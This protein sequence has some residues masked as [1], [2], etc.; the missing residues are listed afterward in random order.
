MQALAREVPIASHVKDYAVRVL[1]ATHPDSEAA[2][3]LVTKYVRYGGSPRGAQAIVLAAKI[4]ALLEGRFNVA[5]RT[6]RRWRRRRCAI[7]SSSTSRARRKGSA[8]TRWS[9]RSWPRRAPNRPSSRPP[10]GPMTAPVARPAEADSREHRCALRR[11]VPAT[12]RAA[13]AGLATADRGPHEGRAPLD[14][15]RSERRVRRLPQLRAPAT[16]CASSTGM[17]TPGWSACSSSCSSRRR[18]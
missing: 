12:P 13:G 2:P 14:A 17:S 15:P 11:D 8:R 1:R 3:E 10:T 9:A 18:T 6:C 16:T 7:G 4:R 5:F